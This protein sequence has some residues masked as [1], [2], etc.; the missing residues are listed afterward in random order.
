MI[1]KSVIVTSI[2]G[3]RGIKKEQGLKVNDWED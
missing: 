3:R 2:D 1:N